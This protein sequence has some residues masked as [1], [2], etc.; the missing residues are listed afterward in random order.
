M[1]D[2]RRQKA[3]LRSEMLK[4]RNALS[5]VDH[6]AYSLSVCDQLEDFIDAVGAQV[7]HSFVPFGSEVAIL[8]A[9]KKYM[10]NNYTIVT[11]KVMDPPRMKNIVTR[12]F[13]KMERNK[14]G[15]LESTS[16][17][18]YSGAYDLIFVPGLAFSRVGG[19][20]LGYGAGYYDYFLA[21]HLKTVKVGIAFDFQLFDDIPAEPHDISV[22]FLITQVSIIRAMPGIYQNG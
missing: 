21:N 12:S 3:R 1:Q 9:L 7:I 11:P 15:V 8:P 19:S 10:E 17:E 2:K 22:D 13:S 20:R 4:R 16:D 18:E 5:E 14:F 6:A